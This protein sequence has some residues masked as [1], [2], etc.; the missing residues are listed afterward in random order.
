MDASPR[1]G[2]TL[3]PLLILMFFTTPGR[4]APLAGPGAWQVLAAARTL[5]DFYVPHGL[6]IG[7]RGNL[8]VADSGNF[9]IVKLTPD[10]RV[11][12][13]FGRQGS[14]PGEF[15]TQPATPYSVFPPLGPESVAVDRQGNVYVADTGNARVEKFSPSGTYLASW[16]VQAAGRVVRQLAVAAAPNNTIL[17]VIG[18]VVACPH[19]CATY[20]LVQRRAPTGAVLGRWQSEIP[21]DGPQD[22]VA[23]PYNVI[24]SVDVAVGPRGTVFVVTTGEEAC[25]KS[26]PSFWAVDRWT[27]DGRRLSGWHGTDFY[28]RPVFPT[29]LAV[30]GRGEIFLADPSDGR[31]EKWSFTGKALATWTSFGSSPYGVVNPRGVAVDARGAVYVSEA[32]TNRI[33]KL[34]AAGKVLAQ[35][36]TG[37]DAPGRFW[38][39]GNVALD[40]SGN[41]WVADTGNGRVQRLAPDGRVLARFG[42]SALGPA[43]ALDRG[44]N[45]YVSRRVGNQI[46]LARYSPTGRPMAQWSN[47]HLADHPSGITVDAHGT[48]YLVGRFEFPYAPNRPADPRNGVDVLVLS[49]AGAQQAL[50]RVGPGIAGG[51]IAV[52]P[53]GDILVVDPTYAKIDRYSRAGQLLSSWFYADDQ[54]PIRAIRSTALTVDARGAVYVAD[55]RRDIVREFTD[56]GAPLAQWG[57]PGALP[58][59]FH[60][61]GGVAVDSRGALYVADSGNNRVQKLTRR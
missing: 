48:I 41:V 42:I 38:R 22:A 31:V 52:S 3:L 14:G 28:G 30:D 15:G 44:G 6:T 29:A 46:V 16:S 27:P 32:V 53:S 35:W 57:S 25:Y 51:G 56:S 45:L 13:R 47:F 23:S 20:Y 55:D 19:D 43:I 33:V 2:L 5:P 61:P 37:G 9:R 50:F 49:A 1:R 39:P 21:P 40:G 18:A 7:G 60:R 26:C 11:L 59:Q 4:A 10:G 58:G 34:S 8:Y 17:V 36:G 54:R 12:G 24:R